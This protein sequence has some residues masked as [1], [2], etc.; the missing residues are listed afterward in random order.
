MDPLVQEFKSHCQSVINQLKEDLKTIRTGK[1]NPALLE[2]IIV[3]T[4]G[5]QTKLHLKELATI[6]LEGPAALSITPFDQS[7]KEDIEKAIQRSPLGITP[8]PQ[9]LKII[10]NIPP[11]S[12]EQREK[13]IK[14]ISTKIEEKKVIVRSH[15]DE[16]R[17]KIKHMLE[18]STITE[19]DKFRREKDVDTYTQQVMEDMQKLKDNKEKE[20]REI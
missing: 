11:L 2:G 20:I 4:Y 18:Q 7:T 14:L 12:E 3:E 5:G 16:V 19:D 17:K 8:Q 9:G 10:I 1:A 13:Y 15:R 6:A